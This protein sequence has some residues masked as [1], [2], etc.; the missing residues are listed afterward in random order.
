M[1][2]R[3]HVIL[4]SRSAS[5]K[6]LPG[7]TA[8][9]APARMANAATTGRRLRRTRAPPATSQRRFRTRYPLLLLGRDHN[10]HDQRQNA[11]EEPEDAPAEWVAGLGRCGDRGDDRPYHATNDEENVV[12][13]A[14]NETCGLRL[15]VAGQQQLMKHDDLLGAERGH[16]ADPGFRVPGW[17]GIKLS[18]TGRRPSG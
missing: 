16:P 13:A 8:R 6:E 15:A 1:Q 2:K 9:Q 12:D 18:R 14:Q 3:T 17:A 10:H 11:E 5:A 4:P 7:S